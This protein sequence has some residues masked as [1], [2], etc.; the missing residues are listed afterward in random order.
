MQ[1]IDKL[2]KGDSNTVEP[3]EDAMDDFM[4]H[5]Q[6]GLPDTLWV[7]GSK[8]GTWSRTAIPPSGPLPGSNGAARYGTRTTATG[9]WDNAGT[10]HTPVHLSCDAGN[11]RTK[12]VS[13]HT[14]Y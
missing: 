6:K 12:G 1:V 7:T 8:I 5:I 2:Q 14:D 9:S 4:T 10:G 3:K 13:C 11:S